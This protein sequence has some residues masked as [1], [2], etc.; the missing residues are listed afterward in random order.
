[1]CRSS[2][3]WQPELRI[4]SFGKFELPLGIQDQERRVVPIWRDSRTAIALGDQSPL[5]REPQSLV[6]RHE[7]EETRQD[8]LRNKT[9]GHAADLVASAVSIGEHGMA[10]DA[11]RFL[12][13][14]AEEITPS[15]ERCVKR[16]LNGDKDLDVPA[17][18]KN[19]Q[20]SIHWCRRRLKAGPRNPLMWLDLARDFSALGQLSKARRALIIGYSLAP[21]NRLVLRTAARFFL[22]DDNVARALD[23]LWRAE[24]LL[25]DPWLLAAEIAMADAA[26]RTSRHVRRGRE[27]L[28]SKQ[29]PDREL[30]ELASALGT[31]ELKAGKVRHSKRLFR[32]ALMDPTDNTIAQVGWV[33]RMVPELSF[34]VDDVSSRGSYEATAWNRILQGEWAES[35][36]AAR[37]WHADEPFSCRPA[38]LGSWVAGSMI[39]DY[40]TAIEIAQSGLL[41]NRDD[42]R[43]TNNLACSLACSDKLQEAED[44]LS[45]VD[46]KRA[47]KEWRTASSSNCGIDFLPARRDIQRPLWL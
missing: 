32:S 5:R 9:V 8:W 19:R 20:A 39:Q 26:G 23:V 4:G 1:M 6:R 12:M 27:I 11:A 25:V 47:P 3:S 18:G 34:D 15:L 31:L 10:K 41:A 21:R 45:T 30:S 2:I 16:I 46:V 13:D 22:H 33:M 7:I 14:L 40:E 35:L 38:I 44:Q 36:E 28:H 17:L 24:Q 37:K 42:P 29:Y 43:L